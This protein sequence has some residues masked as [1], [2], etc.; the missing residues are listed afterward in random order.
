MQSDHICPLNFSLS[1]SLSAWLD[2]L[3]LPDKVCEQRARWIS[4]GRRG[5]ILYRPIHNGRWIGIF[6]PI[7]V[8][9]VGVVVVVVCV[10]VWNAHF[11]GVGPLFFY[12]GR[13]GT[14][15]YLSRIEQ[16]ISSETCEW[17][18]KDNKFETAEGILP[19]K[20]CGR[21]PTGYRVRSFS[22]ATVGWFISHSCGRPTHVWNR[23]R[24][25]TLVIFFRSE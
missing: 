19:E 9:V 11:S 22:S 15:A 18:E 16:R 4:R 1:L 5:G 7:F 20:R 14:C 23:R 10:P 25:T 3:L 6:W 13:I 17:L 21:R 24:K 12:M 8:V 2:K